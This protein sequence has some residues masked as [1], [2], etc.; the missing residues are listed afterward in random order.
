M[1]PFIMQLRPLQAAFVSDRSPERFSITGQPR[2]F[3]PV[4]QA[5][6]SLSKGCLDAAQVGDLAV[7]KPLLLRG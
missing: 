1:L 6:I 4:P 3:L 2:P 7:D 5:R